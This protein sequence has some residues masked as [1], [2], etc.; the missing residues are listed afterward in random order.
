MS[1]GLALFIVALGSMITVGANM[2]AIRMLTNRIK[3]L[4][5]QMRRLRAGLLP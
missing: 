4:E 1:Q 3:V 2:L 5:R